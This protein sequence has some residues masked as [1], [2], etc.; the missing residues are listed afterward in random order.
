MVTPTTPGPSPWYLRGSS[1]RIKVHGQSC[2]WESYDGPTLSGLSRLRTPGGDTLM[3]VDFYCYVQALNN[4]SLLV[5]Y[6]VDRGQISPRIVFTLVDC[7]TLHVLENASSEAADIKTKK[8]KLRFRGGDPVTFEFPTGV[9]EG[10]HPISSPMEFDA[11]PEVLALADF[12]PLEMQS[13]EMRRAIFAFDFKSKHVSVMPQRWFNEGGYDF[14]YQWIT[15]VQRD[16]KTGQI[17]GEGF[18]IGDFRLDASGTL[19]ADG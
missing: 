18:R 4:E 12:G 11:L 19:L 6:E 10:R 9:N 1:A 3:F 2:S 8:D 13:N 7:R 16:P 17:V 5:W 14:G 15:R